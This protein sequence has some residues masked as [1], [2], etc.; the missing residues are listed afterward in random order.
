M[1]LVFFHWARW[2][3]AGVHGLAR[4]VHFITTLVGHVH[5]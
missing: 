2:F 1:K 5:V 4:F 3:G